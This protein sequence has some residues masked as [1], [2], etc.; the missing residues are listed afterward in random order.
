M[1]KPENPYA[2]P[3]GVPHMT[4][5]EPEWGMSLRDHFAGLALV[6]MTTWA[7]C[8]ENGYAQPDQAAVWKAKAE[9]AYG[10]ADAMLSA[11]QTTDREDGK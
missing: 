8:D 11:R 3:L 6:G 10:M 7:P 1:A 5:Y 9:W 2:F 4:E